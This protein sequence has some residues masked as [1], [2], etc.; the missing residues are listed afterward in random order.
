MIGLDRLRHRRCA[1]IGWASCYY[2]CLVFL[3]HHP[4]VNKE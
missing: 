1:L 4:Q 2:Y 3:Y